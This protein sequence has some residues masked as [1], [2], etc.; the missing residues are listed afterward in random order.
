MNINFVISEANKILSQ[1]NIRYSELD[2][3]ILLSKV[4]NKERDYIILNSKKEL[5]K[6]S[7]SLFKRLIKLRSFGKPIAY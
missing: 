4:L 6:E 3:E 7:Y 2:S 1:A 5:S